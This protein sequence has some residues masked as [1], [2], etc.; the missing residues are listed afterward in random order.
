MSREWKPGDVAV[1]EYRGVQSRAMVVEG[2]ICPA[3]HPKRPHWHGQSGGWNHLTDALVD[4]HP[5]VVIDAEDREQVERLGRDF[6]ESDHIAPWHD[7]HGETRSQIC[8]AMQAALRSLLAPEKPD[9]PQGLGAVV[10]D[11]TGRRW[12]RVAIGGVGWIECNAM[13]VLDAGKDIGRSY[14]RI[15]AVRVLSEGVPQ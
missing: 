6:H 7:L 10:E 9:E 15:D 13:T 5:L 3:T 8:D 4:F 11:S 1:T 14:K 2:R 12:V